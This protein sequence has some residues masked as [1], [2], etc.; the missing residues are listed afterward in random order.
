MFNGWRS[1]HSQRAYLVYH[2]QIIR[3]RRA[4]PAAMVVARCHARSVWR[5]AGVRRV[6]REVV[7]PRGISRPPRHETTDPLVPRQRS[8][9][10]SQA[11]KGTIGVFEKSTIDLGKNLPIVP[12]ARS[13]GW[14]ACRNIH[15][16]PTGWLVS[17]CTFW[18]LCRPL[19]LSQFVARK[20]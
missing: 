14:K 16:C 3:P 10:F 15:S 20:I 8:S 1:P 7:R 2:D 6:V 19:N 12:A 5:W 17:S 18:P 13:K 11:S 9:A 4:C